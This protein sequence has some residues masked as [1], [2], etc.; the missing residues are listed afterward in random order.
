MAEDVR[1]QAD[2]KASNLKM[3]AELKQQLRTWNQT[4]LPKLALEATS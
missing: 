1:E 4:L 2:R 3:L